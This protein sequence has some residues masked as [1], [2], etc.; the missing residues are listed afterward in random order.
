LTDPP[1]SPARPRDQVW[2]AIIAAVVS[3][4]CLAV[5]TGGAYY[6]LIGLLAANVFEGTRRALARRRHAASSRT[7]RLGAQ[8][9]TALTGAS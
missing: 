9:N 5:N 7:A 4:A 1:T 6:L 8:F 3:V 2:F